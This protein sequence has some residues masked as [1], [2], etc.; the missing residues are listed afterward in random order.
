MERYLLGLHHE[1]KFICHATI[2]MP[3]VIFVP[4]NFRTFAHAKENRN[5][6]ELK[7]SRDKK[8]KSRNFIACKSL[9]MAV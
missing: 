1:I 8:G 3:F 9:L 7:L 2:I 4:Q 6:G 5:K